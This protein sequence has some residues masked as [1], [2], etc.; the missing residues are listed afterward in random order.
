MVWTITAWPHNLK[1]RE[2]FSSHKRFNLL[3]GVSHNSNSVKT[4]ESTTTTSASTATTFQALE[5]GGDYFVSD[6]IALSGQFIF[7]LMSSIDATIKGYNLG[8]RYYYLK[9]GYQ[10]ESLIRGTKIESAPGWTPF[11][12]AGFAVRDF[13]FTNASISFKGPEAGTGLDFHYRQHFFLRGQVTYQMLYNT[14]TRTLSGFSAG[15][16]AGFSF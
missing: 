2:T 9:S 3:L 6:R 4:K 13:D 16:S 15:V 10:S 14:S 7:S 1:A 11:M 12:I 8:F 5:L